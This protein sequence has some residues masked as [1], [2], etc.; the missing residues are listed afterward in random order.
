MNAAFAAHPSLLQNDEI[1]AIQGP[2]AVAAAEVDSMM[3][4]ERRTEITALLGN[5]AEPYNVALYSGTSHGFGVRANVSDPQQKF[6]KESAF[7][8][9]VRWFENWA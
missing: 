8:Q 3:S 4:P 1:V 6:G 9:A 5:T 2:V 7:F